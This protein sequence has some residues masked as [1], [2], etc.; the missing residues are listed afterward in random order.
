VIATFFEALSTGICTVP[1]ILVA[2]RLSWH[3][4]QRPPSSCFTA[5]M[6]VTYT[7][8]SLK[9]HNPASKHVLRRRCAEVR[10]ASLRN[11]NYGPYIPL[12]KHCASVTSCRPLQDCY[13]TTKFHT[14]RPLK[15][16]L[17]WYSFDIPGSK[18]VSWE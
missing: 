8:D 5:S 4:E 6:G 3:P 2:H 1:G 10:Q 9:H 11:S 13:E 12:P 16:Q 18:L 14:Q 15:R 7:T 17:P